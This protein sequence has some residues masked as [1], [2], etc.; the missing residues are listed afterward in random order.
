MRIRIVLLLVGVKTASLNDSVEH[1]VLMLLSSG[2]LV[3]LSDI[4]RAV[5]I[6]VLVSSLTSTILI[7]VHT[8]EI[9][10]QRLVHMLTLKPIHSQQL[11]SQ[12]HIALRPGYLL[13]QFSLN[14]HQ[15][16][17]REPAN[18]RQAYGQYYCNS[19]ENVLNGHLISFV[20]SRLN[21]DSVGPS[22]DQT[23]A[24]KKSA[25]VKPPELVQS[26]RVTPCKVF[27]KVKVD[28]E[29]VL[30]ESRDE[31]WGNKLHSHDKV[32]QH[33]DE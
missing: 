5:K 8:V 12:G 15:L 16:V 17:L 9:G 19:H 28:S 29:L 20:K 30:F 14:F 2:L 4:H 22:C 27:S 26:C 31:N 7:E 11:G 33:M 10:G 1:I 32:P 6:L 3:D 13:L 21:L 25:K 18:S 24:Q 23:E